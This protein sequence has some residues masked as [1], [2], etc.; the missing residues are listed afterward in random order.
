[1]QPLD[2]ITV[3]DLSI[4]LP[5]LYGT[6]LLEQ[7]GAEVLKIESPGGDPLKHRGPTTEHE[8]GKIYA[9]LNEGKRC[10]EIDL[11]IFDGL[12]TVF[13]APAARFVAPLWCRK[14]R[15][16]IMVDP[17]AAS[18]NLICDA[19]HV[20]YL[21]SRHRRQDRILHR[22]RFRLLLLLC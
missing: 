10:F 22:S 17:D 5:G 7:L 8:V 4:T 9:A 19:V 2:D 18:P 1:M 12:D 13:D 20:A 15:G 6:K 14:V 21:R 3:V 16:S 11:K